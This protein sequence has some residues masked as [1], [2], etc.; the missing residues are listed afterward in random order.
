MLGIDNSKWYD[1]QVLRLDEDEY[2]VSA[3]ETNKD[4]NYQGVKIS[5]ISK[6]VKSRVAIPL[7]F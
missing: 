7:K 3:I 1:K 6:Y 4:A 2:V 5:D